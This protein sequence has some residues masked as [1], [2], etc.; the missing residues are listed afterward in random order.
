MATDNIAVVRRFF[1][2]A[3][4]NKDYPVLDQLISPEFDNHGFKDTKK[5]AEGIRDVII[6]FT[7][8]FPDLHVTLEECLSSDD[9]V[10]CRGYF[11]GTHQQ[12]F[13]GIEPRGEH[14]KVPFIDIW[15]LKDGKAIEYWLQMDLMGMAQQA[16]TAPIQMAA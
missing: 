14:V 2:E 3:V 7:N 15:K 12:T 5:G 9:C 6:M 4:N 16:K 8:S 11:E 10:I 13:M 1:D